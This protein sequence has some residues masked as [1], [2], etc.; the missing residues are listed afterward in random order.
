[1]SCA[2]YRNRRTCQLECFSNKSKW[3]FPLNKFIRRTLRRGSLHFRW[4]RDVQKHLSKNHSNV[5]QR[6]IHNSLAVLRGLHLPLNGWEKVSQNISCQREIIPWILRFEAKALVKISYFRLFQRPPHNWRHC[7]SKEN[8][9]WEFVAFYMTILTLASG[10][11]D[12]VTGMFW[13][14]A[15]VY[16]WS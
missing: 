12:H 4:Q 7:L 9:L 6:R 13:H 8:I 2:Q 11:K 14:W 15:L 3:H 16:V 10:K 1:M 5:I